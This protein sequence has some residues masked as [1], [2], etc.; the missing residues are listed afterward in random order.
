NEGRY[1]GALAL[2]GDLEPQKRTEA[3]LRD[4]IEELR[5]KIDAEARAKAPAPAAAHER[6][7]PLALRS[8]AAGPVCG[9]YLGI[10]AMLP[11][12]TVVG[13]AIG[14]SRDADLWGEDGDCD[15]SDRG[16]KPPRAG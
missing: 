9:A 3:R 5:A 16:V 10:V 12:G 7:L 14:S 13:S 4:E 11:A 6:A 8:A 15:R 1:A 2:F